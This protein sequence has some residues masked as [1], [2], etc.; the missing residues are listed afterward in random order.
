MKK[1]IKIVQLFCFLSYFPVVMAFVSKEKSNITCQEVKS[2]LLVNTEKSLISEEMMNA[3][4]RKTF[5]N[6]E[7]VPVSDINKHEMEERIKRN[8]VVED[9]NIFTT[10]GGVVY[11]RVKQRD[12]LLRVFSNSGTYYMDKD[13]LL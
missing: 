5:Q 1:F 10:P 3:L 4:V 2:V 7:G 9:C 12:P 8:A 13:G 11:A 6:L